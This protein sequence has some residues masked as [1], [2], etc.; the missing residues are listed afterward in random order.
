MNE[1]HQET[2]ES[3]APLILTVP[4][5]GFVVTLHLDSLCRPNRAAFSD[6]TFARGK[7]E[8][9]REVLGGITTSRFSPAFSARRPFLFPFRRARQ[10]SP[11][12]LPPN[13]RL[14]KVHWLAL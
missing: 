11:S 3:K 14:L 5:Y 9:T 1:K 6:E 2:G 10:A 4:A 12:A 7:D 8:L 13:R